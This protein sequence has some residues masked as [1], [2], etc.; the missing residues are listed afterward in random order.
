MSELEMQPAP[1]GQPTESI[2]R[3]LEHSKARRGEW[4]STVEE[5]EERL[6]SARAMRDGYTEEV[7]LYMYQIKLREGVGDE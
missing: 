7:A 1:T 4:A 5:L 3:Y 6:R 2:R